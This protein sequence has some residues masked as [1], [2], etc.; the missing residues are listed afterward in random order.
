MGN[1]IANRS[2]QRG[3]LRLE[4]VDYGTLRDIAFD[5]EHDLALNPSER[6]QMVRKHDAN[7]GKV[8]TST[9]STEGRSRTIE[10]HESPESAD[11]YT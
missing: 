1:V 5:I 10:V 8:W 2:S 9:A 6:P 7:H 3:I 11:A 4:S